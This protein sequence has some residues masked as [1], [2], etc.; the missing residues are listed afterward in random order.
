MSKMITSN[1][2]NVNNNEKEKNEAAEN[3]FKGT[4]FLNNDEKKL[5]SKWIHPNKIIKFNLLFITA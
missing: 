1:E 4:S 2:N 5:I 3:S